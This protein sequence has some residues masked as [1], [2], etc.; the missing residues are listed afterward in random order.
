MNP[1]I[2]SLALLASLAV[3]GSVLAQELQLCRIFDSFPDR[4]DTEIDQFIQ[5]VNCGKVR[6]LVSECSK[7]N[8]VD[9][10]VVGC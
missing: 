10:K 4:S 1:M 2:K 5:S 6:T 9:D 8:L 7:V 3:S